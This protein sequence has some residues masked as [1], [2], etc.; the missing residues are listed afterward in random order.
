MRHFCCKQFVIFDVK[1]LSLG[2]SVMRVLQK[3]TILTIFRVEQIGL[4]KFP[5]NSSLIYNLDF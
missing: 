3:S 5:Y 4:D 2:P 1:F